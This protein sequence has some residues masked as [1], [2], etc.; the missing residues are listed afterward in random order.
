[1][2]KNTT[3]Y[4]G[5]GVAV[6]VIFCGLSLGWLVQDM[7]NHSYMAILWAVLLVLWVTNLSNHIKA[8]QKMRAAK[9]ER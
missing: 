7:V 8:H 3:R 9:V 2:D 1:M 5:L 6:S 4:T